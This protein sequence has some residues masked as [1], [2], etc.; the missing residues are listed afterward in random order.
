MDIDVDAGSLV[1]MAQRYRG[2]GP[3]VVDEL[4][5]AMTRSVLA[6]ERSS[7]QLAP[8]KT[9][10][11]R[12]S[13]THEVRAGAGGIVGVVGT[14]LPYARIVEEG[15]G[16]VVAR[17]ARVLRFV[18]NGQ[19]IYRRSVGPAKGKPYLKPALVA[20]RAKIERE[21]AQVPRRVLAR[22]GAR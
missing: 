14:N 10:T 21:F 2:A 1:R 4:D 18:V 5:K 13:L 3:I 19:V 20:N 11:L 6:V 9:G 17:N 12:R 7:K 15:R 16:P 22:L 8:V